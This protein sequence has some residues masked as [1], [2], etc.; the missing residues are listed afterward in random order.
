[1]YKSSLWSQTTTAHPVTR[2]FVP[3]PPPVLAEI[4]NQGEFLCK[5]HRVF[6]GGTI[7]LYNHSVGNFSM[8][9]LVWL[10]LFFPY[11]D[12]LEVCLKPKPWTLFANVGFSCNMIQFWCVCGTENLITTRPEGRNTRQNKSPK[13]LCKTEQ[14]WQ[15]GFKWP[16][17]TPENSCCKNLLCLHHVD[18]AVF[19]RRVNQLQFLKNKVV[20]CQLNETW[21]LQGDLCKQC[22]LPWAA[23]WLVNLPELQMFLC[24][25]DSLGKAPFL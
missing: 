20:G 4:K 7:L 21:W 5:E 25:P 22:L 9:F 13:V 14:S 2:E 12:V 19:S 15:W 8:L 6:L 23:W 24:A 16:M 17:S 11:T 1:M 3:K 18:K 10:F